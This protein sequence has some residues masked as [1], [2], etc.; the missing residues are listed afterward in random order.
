MKFT[1]KLRRRDEHNEIFVH[2]S[3]YEYK[4]GVSIMLTKADQA[5]FWAFTSYVINFNILADQEKKKNRT[6][7]VE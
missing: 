1:N 4:E 7:L 6:P 2:R 3:S 5:R